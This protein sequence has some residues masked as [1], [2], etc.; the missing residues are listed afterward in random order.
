MA[1]TVN[2][3]ATLSNLANGGTVGSGTPA[4]SNY[5]CPA[6]TTTL[7]ILACA[8]SAAP[9]VE[10][11][12]S[13]NSV[14][15]TLVASSFQSNTGGDQTSIWY[16]NN[17]TTGSLLTFSLTWSQSVTGGGGAILVPLSGT[18]T[19][20][21]TVGTVGKGT[22]N[23]AVTS[24]SLALA[25]ATANDLAVGIICVDGGS[26]VPTVTDGQTNLINATSRGSIRMLGSDAAGTATGMTWSAFS[27]ANLYTASGVAFLGAASV[28]SVPLLGQILM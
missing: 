11:A 27:I 28:V 1:V 19:S 10:T 24:G 14:A 16:L 26:G 25:G 9:A 21:S 12:V 20:G 5:N 6:G 13:Y 3:S 8:N 15:A 17:P 4:T 7:V 18:N 22:S 23:T 2:G